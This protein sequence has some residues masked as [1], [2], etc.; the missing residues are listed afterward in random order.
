MW[1]GDAIEEPA[2][3][4]D[5]H[6]AAGVILQRILKGAQGI[7]VEIVGRFVEQQHIGTAS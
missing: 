4:A 6:R 5:D 7:H 1:G 3:V 2:I